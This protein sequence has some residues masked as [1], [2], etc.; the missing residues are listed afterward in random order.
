MCGIV[1]YIGKRQAAPHP[2]INVTVFLPGGNRILF[3]T[4]SRL[5]KPV[6]FSRGTVVVTLASG[7][8]GTSGTVVVMLATGTSGTSG[9]VV[10]MLA[11]GTSGTVVVMLASELQEL[12]VRL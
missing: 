9:T 1:G 3:Y 12:Q 10:V 4:S 8:S 7:T 5:T 2:A 11:S 6:L